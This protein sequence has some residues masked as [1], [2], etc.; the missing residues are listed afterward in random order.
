VSSIANA[1]AVTPGGLGINE[2]TVSSAL[3]ALGTPFPASAQ[4]AV[5]NR[6]LVAVA[7]GMCGVAG[8][9]IALAA[10]SARRAV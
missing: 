1:L 10:R 3:F 5:V 4:W 8:L 2:W 7:A 6:V 9:L